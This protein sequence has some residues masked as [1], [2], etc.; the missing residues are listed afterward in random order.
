MH[1][2]EAPVV[3]FVARAGSGKTTATNFVKSLK[4]RYF[5]TVSFAAP[6]KKLAGAL[7][8]FEDEQLYGSLKETMDPRYG[9][10]PREFMQRLGNEARLHIHDRVWV[11]AAM[12][13]VSAVRHRG[14]VALIDDC[15]YA[16]EAEAIRNIGGLVIKIE[17]P[18]RVSAAD[19]NHPSEKG[20]DKIRAEYTIINHQ[21]DGLDA[22]FDKIRTILKQEDVL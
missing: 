4:P 7:M 20:V 10:T 1:E 16:N 2:R 14:K 21:K 6:L 15:R 8:G 19:P 18:D 17:S 12:N 11:D 9:M 13:R 22:F 5:E 3:A